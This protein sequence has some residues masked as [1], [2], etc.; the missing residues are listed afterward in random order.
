M[1]LA[2]PFPVPWHLVPAN[3]LYSLRLAWS[4]YNNA[5]FVALRRDFKARYGFKPFTV[6]PMDLA[7]NPEPGLKRIVAAMPELDY[8]FPGLGDDVVMCGPIMKPFLALDDSDASL[9]AWLSR[10][11]TI[12][13]NLGSHRAVN[14]DLA[15]EMATAL[16]V[17]MAAAASAAERLGRPE[18]ARLQVL[19][20]LKQTGG[21][22][23]RGFT[24]YPID[25]PGSR[26]HGIL[27]G[28]MDADRVR[29]VD[30][31]AAEP[32]SILDSGH[33]ICYVHHAGAN[34]ALEGLL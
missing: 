21:T 33:V 23:Y 34:A 30:W 28:M 1:A 17:V 19:W 20:K 18:L 5:P 15:V 12:F 13:I 9:L 4:C 32:L 14:E 2:Y 8:P 7:E 16:R 25:E 29:V 22:W 6:A 26:L 3:M 24:K 11:P 10:G 27:G 31:V